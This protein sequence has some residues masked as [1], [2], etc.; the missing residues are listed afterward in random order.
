MFLLFLVGFG[1]R[2]CREQTSCSPSQPAARLLW[3]SSHS[4][5]PLLCFSQGGGERR[6]GRAAFCSFSSAAHL[7][8]YYVKE[9]ESIAEQWVM[10]FTGKNDDQ[11]QGI[12][13]SR[14]DVSWKIPLF[15]REEGKVQRTLEMVGMTTGTFV[16]KGRRVRSVSEQSYSPKWGHRDS[17]ECQLCK[18]QGHTCNG[19]T[20]WLP[21][22][23]EEKEQIWILRCKKKPIYSW[24][25]LKIQLLNSALPSNHWG[26]DLEWVDGTAC[27]IIMA[28]YCICLCQVPLKW[29]KVSL[30]NWLA[31]GLVRGQARNDSKAQI[32]KC[33]LEL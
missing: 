1:R 15:H 6:L 10:L 18:K 25:Q 21:L 16:R 13:P 9:M 32:S 17:K 11:R 12:T 26:L 31:E 20:T 29:S 7:V 24:I 3:E 14:T 33:V 27:G 22:M 30:S 2:L 28:Y 4:P 8:G 23:W 19:F 5:L